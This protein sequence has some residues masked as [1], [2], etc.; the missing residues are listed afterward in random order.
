MIYTLII[1][2]I[3]CLYMI[4]KDTVSTVETSCTGNCNQGKNC[5]CVI[6]IYKDTQ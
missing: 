4:Y 1:V 6:N 2:A 5:S 3:L